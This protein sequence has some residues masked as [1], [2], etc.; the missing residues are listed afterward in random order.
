MRKILFAMACFVL[1]LSL[2]GCETDSSGNSDSYSSQNT[3][4]AEAMVKKAL[5][6]DEWP[7]MD[8]VTEQIYVNTLFA[9]DI[10][11]EDC[12]DYCLASNIISSQLYRILVIKPKADK[13]EAIEAAIDEYYE[14]VRSGEAAAYIDQQA[15][16][17]GSIKGK[18]EGGY[19]YLIVHPNGTLVADKM[20]S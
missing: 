5:E 6:A 2:C 7:A 19:I 9:D 13:A 15:S 10:V 8:Y 18:I 3:A 12:E 4:N 11:L 17:A 16:A 1:M 14:Y 20:L